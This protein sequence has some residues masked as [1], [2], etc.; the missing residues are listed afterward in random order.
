MKTIF[1]MQMAEARRIV[2]RENGIIEICDD[3]KTSSTDQGHAFAQR[4]DAFP[5]N[6]SSKAYDFITARF[7]LGRIT[8]SDTEPLWVIGAHLTDHHDLIVFQYADG[9]EE[10]WQLTGADNQWRLQ[11]KQLVSNDEHAFLCEV[12]RQSSYLDLWHIDPLTQILNDAM[13]N[14]KGSEAE[15]LE[16]PT[17]EL[18]YYNVFPRHCFHLSQDNDVAERQPPTRATINKR[19]QEVPFGPGY[20]D[21]EKNSNGNLDECVW[22]VVWTS[23]APHPSLEI[24]LGIG[25]AMHAYRGAIAMNPASVENDFGP[26]F[27]Q[28][29]LCCLP[30]NLRRI[31]DNLVAPKA[32]VVVTVPAYEDFWSRDICWNYE[33]T[34]LV[35]PSVT[36]DLIRQYLVWRFDDPTA[37]SHGCEDA[38]AEL[39]LLAGRHFM[40]TGDTEFVSRYIEQYHELARHLETITEAGGGL[41]LAYGSWDGQGMPIHAI[42]PYLTAEVYAALQRL[43]EMDKAI[44]EDAMATYWRDLAAAIK[45]QALRDYREGGLWH[46]QEQRFINR[47]DF[48]DPALWGARHQQW[49][50]GERMETA[51]ART[52]VAMYQ[53]VIAIWFGLLDDEDKIQQFYQRIDK[54]YTYASGRGGVTF[55]PLIIQNFMALMDVCVRQRHGIPG[56]DRLLQLILDHALDGGAP[57][58]EKA[59]GAYACSGPENPA[60]E[61]KFYPQGHTGRAWDNAPYFT[62][63]MKLHYGL[64]CDAAGLI[65]NDPK[66]IANYPL[67]QV[68][69]LQIGTA[70]YNITWQT[71]GPI[72]SIMVDSQIIEGRRIP[73]SDGEHDVVVGGNE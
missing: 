45:A 46:T 52:E 32:N 40:L 36:A 22:Q 28:M 70:V 67:T 9:N 33:L 50:C 1:E 57:L 62:L 42:E 56:A 12:P 30:L 47:L 24:T 20:G 10:T 63:V 72:G 54:T 26:F 7:R 4:D 37:T 61:W 6:Q 34:Y 55:P 41:P 19:T 18:F 35:A 65:I 13:P 59:F 73:Y 25:A 58:T 44:G 11:G 60:G 48:R 29:Y 16:H 69:G 53:N 66:P 5:V 71:R 15:S 49:N 31:K 38:E 51:V 21:W 23:Q 3:Q 8:V 64:D 2:C 39:I 27:D 14:S 17:D 43:A 68:R